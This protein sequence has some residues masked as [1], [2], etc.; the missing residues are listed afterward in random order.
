[1]YASMFTKSHRGVLAEQDET[2]FV[3][4]LQSADFV[5]GARKPGS[6]FCGGFILQVLPLPTDAR[7]IRTLPQRFDQRGIFVLMRAFAPSKLTLDND[8]R[9]LPGNI[10]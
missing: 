4:R 10:D 1:M 8:S 2:R 3:A 5:L 7:D 9:L 6:F